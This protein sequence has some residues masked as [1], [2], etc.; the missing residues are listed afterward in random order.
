MIDNQSFIQR[1]S[2]WVNDNGVIKVRDT[3]WTVLL[4]TL[5]MMGSTDP[6]VD[7]AVSTSILDNYSGVIITLTG[8]GNSQTLENPT[9]VTAG[10]KFTV[11]SDD[12]NS[13]YTIEVNGITMSAGEAQR[14]VWDGSVWIAITAVDADDI[15]FTPAGSIIATDVQAAIE[16]LDNEKLALAGGVMTGDIDMGGYS[17]PACQSIANLAGQG[18]ALK[19][20]GVDDFGNLDALAAE[21]VDVNNAEGAIVWKGQIHDFVTG[22]DR[23][24]SFGDTS[25]DEFLF[26]DVSPINNKL[27]GYCRIVTND[28]WVFETDNTFEED[29]EYEF[30]LK[31][32]G[33]TPSLYVNGKLEPITFSDESDKTAWF[34][35]LTSVDNGILGCLEIGGSG[36]T[37]FLN[38]SLNKFYAL[39]VCP[40]AG[41]VLAMYEGGNVPFEWI[42]ADM[43]DIVSNG[44]DWTGATGTT[45]PTGWTDIFA[46]I[47]SIIADGG[48]GG[49]GDASLKIEVNATPTTNP[50]IVEGI[51]T[52]IG[53]EYHLSF[54]FKHGTGTAGRVAVG[55]TSGSTNLYNSGN[56]TDAGWTKYNITFTAITTTSYVLV[57]TFSS[58]V[59][60]Y[61]EFDAVA[62][63][64]IGVV[65]QYEQDGIGHNQLL[66]KSGNEFH[67]SIDGAVPINLPVSH[68]DKYIEKTITADTLLTGIVP[69]GYTLDK[70]IFKETAGNQAILDCGTSDG[71][72]DVF[73]GVTIA[74][75]DTTTVQIGK[76][77]SDTAVTT[78]DINDDQAGSSW[79]S[80]SIDIVIVMKRGEV[81]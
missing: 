12:G 48:P 41:E 68:T 53:K 72:N 62:V 81:I 17:L 42:G 4:P 60:Q 11:V 57:Q 38:C 67:G 61:E 47:F 52:E 14:F 66:D 2:P 26:L 56:I 35:V 44:Q 59:G 73:T 39:N 5:E 75:S 27:R 69:I 78:L 15:A 77:F 76:T 63:T 71:G 70:I 23:V 1:T 32:D 79:N 43:S 22:Y 50:H 29:D 33:V 16:E 25:G 51:A 31:H 46:G 28:K 65:G 45:P 7:A 18:A 21:L 30:T 37:N 19:F 55:S 49:V 10:K 3:D 20:D 40:T 80:A 6:A 58:T 74:A 24:W 8:A 54:W 9:N 13:G 64:Q 34:S 36:K